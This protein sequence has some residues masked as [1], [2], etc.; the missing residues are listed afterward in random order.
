MLFNF[1]SRYLVRYRSRDVF[2]LGGRSPPTSHGKTKPWYSGP[3]RRPTR[4]RLRGYHP[5]RRG[6]P[7][8][9]GY[10]VSA[11]W[12]SNP[13]PRARNPT[14]PPAHRRQVWFGLSPFRSP[15]LRGSRLI[16]L[17]PPTKMFP[18]G[19]FPSRVWGLPRPQMPRVYP[20]REFP[21]GDPGFDGCLRL[22]RA[23]RRL[24]RPSSAPEPSH[25]P[26]GVMPQ[27]PR[28]SQPGICCELPA[29]IEAIQPLTNQPYKGPHKRRSRNTL[30]HPKPQIPKGR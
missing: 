15:L 1:P 25:P 26:R 16:S 12:G 3:R 20:W 30:T 22:P 5:L 27:A 9:F 2:S 13:Q 14:S 11:C 6:F 19:G 18:F 17:P 7:A 10:L 21:F 8:H 23:Y 4:F 28:G 29:L 24:P